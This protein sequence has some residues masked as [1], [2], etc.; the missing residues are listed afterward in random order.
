MLSGCHIIGSSLAVAAVRP[1]RVL[2][3][4]ARRLIEEQSRAVAANDWARVRDLGNQLGDLGRA[5]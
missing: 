5:A 2:C 1:A 3:A 4:A